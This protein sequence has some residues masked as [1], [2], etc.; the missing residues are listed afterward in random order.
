MFLAF[1]IELLKHDK[2]DRKETLMLVR[3]WIPM[4]VFLAGGT[5]AT[6]A[7][8]G[9]DSSDSPGSA[10]VE[11]SWIIDGFDMRGCYL[12][13]QECPNGAFTGFQTCAS[14]TS[15]TGCPGTMQSRGRWSESYTGR[16]PEWIPCG[17]VGQTYAVMACQCFGDFFGYCMGPCR[18]TGGVVL[19]D[20]PCTGTL[21]RVVSCEN[22]G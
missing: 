1:G 7:D 8:S 12:A 10:I 21:L 18:P 14:A 19:A 17:Q 13:P 6:I 4:L 20:V 15:T 11:C 2:R 3:T 9:I 16:Q 22:P 5:V